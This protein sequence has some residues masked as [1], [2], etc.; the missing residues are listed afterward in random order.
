[1][2]LSSCSSSE[3][4]NK[5]D[6]SSEVGS[7]H[8][9]IIRNSSP[10]TKAPLGVGAS[11]PVTGAGTTAELSI[12]N[13]GHLF[14]VNSGGV[15]TKYVEIRT[16][17]TGGAN[18]DSWV[19]WNDI[20]NEVYTGIIGTP[21]AVDG[22][23]KNVPS[24]STKVYVFLNLPASG[25]GSLTTAD[26]ANLVGFPISDLNAK[27]VNAN[28]LGS[29]TFG[30][31]S[32]PV[33]GSGD[34]TATPGT[35]LNQSIAYEME[36]SFDL[37]AIAARIELLGFRTKASV[38]HPT[39]TIQSFM[40]TGIYINN[41]YSSLS[42]TGTYG[43]LKNAGS[44]TLHYT[45]L[46]I[47]TFFYDAAQNAD[48]AY[49]YTVDNASVTTNFGRQTT[50]S[51]GVTEVT[52]P[53]PAGQAWGYNI[54]PND[55]TTS[56]QVKANL[57]HL[58]LRLSHVV[59]HDASTN[60]DYARNGSQFVTV[61]GYTSAATIGAQAAGSLA[62]LERGYIYQLGASGSFAISPDDLTSV[63]ETEEISAL[64]TATLIDWQKVEVTPEF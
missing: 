11:N 63:P 21:T 22:V 48:A 54:F 15:V 18:A 19:E 57:P 7:V 9:K 60:T 58:I 2:L 51:A 47:T 31:Q 52:P 24:S 41:Y 46:P 26:A 23:I 10:A 44:D 17:T 5:I 20:D 6:L 36:T 37:K 62:Y 55:L 39:Q 64:V 13:G 1:M 8:L 34:L 3:E 28:N 29:A 53:L 32:V 25:T 43:A 45:P 30:V 40:L 61:K 50:I 35:S 33:S 59:I 16:T 56:V 27:V 4:E 12:G 38:L 42:L 14:F 49:L